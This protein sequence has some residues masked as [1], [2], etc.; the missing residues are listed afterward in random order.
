MKSIHP[1]RNLKLDRVVMNEVEE[2]PLQK[3][4]H[5]QTTS[6][7]KPN[8]PQHYLE[9]CRQELHFRYDRPERQFRYRYHHFGDILRAQ[10]LSQHFGRRLHRALLEEFSIDE[11]WANDTG[12]NS[13][14][15][16]FHAN[17]VR[18]TEKPALCSLLGSTRDILSQ[19]RDRRDIDQMPGPIL[20]HGRQHRVGNVVGTTQ[21][22]A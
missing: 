21:V 22:D 17:S 14:F 3:P 5:R 6:S 19:A 7:A 2:P 13:V 20:P 15:F 9:V 12:T 1:H 8:T 18:Q 10:R 11:P 16:F 4:N